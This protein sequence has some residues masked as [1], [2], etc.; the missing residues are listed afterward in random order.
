MRFSPHFESIWHQLKQWVGIVANGGQE[1]P[2]ALITRLL[3]RHK[4]EVTIKAALG[5]LLRDMF[6]NTA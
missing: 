6:G 2:H 3:L 4:I 1:M 5:S